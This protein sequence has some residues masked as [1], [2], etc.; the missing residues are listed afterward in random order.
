LRRFPALLRTALRLSWD[1][2]PRVLLLAGIL[3]LV[4]GGAVLA[5]L[6]LGRE[7]LQ[8]LV[9]PPGDAFSFA[10]SVP[11]LGALAAVTV[12]VAF[13]NL[14]RSEL[15]RLLGELVSRHATGLVLDAASN[16]TLIDFET[17]EFHNRLLRAWMN[18]GSRPVQMATGL[19]AITGSLL[20]IAGVAGALL[21][22]EPMLLVALLLAYVP[23]WL[24]TAR[25]SKVSY[26]FSVAQ[27][28]RD[29]QRQYLSY[30][31]IER[32]SAPEIRAFDLAPHLRKRYDRLYQER[33][34][35]LVRT[36]RRRLRYGLA[37]GALSSFLTAATIAALVWMI[38]G[39]RLDLA[40]GGAVA[41]A[42][43][44]LG[45]RLQSLAGGAGSLYESSLFLEDFSS[46]VR[47]HSPGDGV[48]PRSADAKP[49]RFGSIQVDDVRFCY[50]SREAP[51]VDGVSLE[52]RAG[53][54]V[55][56]VGE[57]G[58]GKTTLAKLLAG[59]YEPDEGTIRWDGAETRDL[60]PERLR[61]SIGVIFQDFV[62]YYLSARDNIGLGQ[63]A[64]IDV[65]PEIV[66][67]AIRAGADDF[68]SSLAKGYD[69]TLG[70]QFRDAT[71]LSGGQWQ[72][73]ALAR[74]FFRNAPLLILDEPSAAL[75]PRSEA[76]LFER[77]RELYRGRT[78]LLISHR[79]ST[80]R[81]ADRIFV[82]AAGQ[83][84]EAGS[85][86]ELMLLG[87][88]YA[89]MFTAQAAAYVG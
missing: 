54:V 17:A 82:M 21:I 69:T 11:L 38:A 87:G 24:A 9:E 74:A 12:V 56:V 66:D 6:L 34:E 73:V 81:S 42:L 3:Q 83:I 8:H 31:M 28:E 7:L 84:V 33:L 49:L 62:R 75:D 5:Q 72:R 23:A 79:F 43:L 59:L 29:R 63:P 44:I 70:T 50:P 30:L 18:A 40:S 65:H 45:Q 46:F 55:A 37:G 89:E 76:A 1:A 25:A 71:E 67:A 77:V 53:E 20:A 22:I 13:S 41:G 16:A 64:R 10:D 39:E 85:H 2:G 51:S 35:H 88:H 60:D 32:Q 27:T 61:A 52:I 47:R 86:A 80:V 78:V 14:A 4:G 36:V 26:E 58:S 57:N 15:Q 48:N 68:L 19:L